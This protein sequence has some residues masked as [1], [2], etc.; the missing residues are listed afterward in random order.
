MKVF[1]IIYLSYMIVKE[2]GR[3]ARLINFLNTPNAEINDL[4]KEEGGSEVIAK[5]SRI[6]LIAT[7]VLS[8]IMLIGVYLWVCLN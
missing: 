1:V 2:I 3:T 7:S 8:N 5:R 6:I 4:I